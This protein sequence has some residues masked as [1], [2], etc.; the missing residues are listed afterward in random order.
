MNPSNTDWSTERILRTLFRNPPPF[1]VINITL[2]WILYPPLS[3][4]P[5]TKSFEMVTYSIDGA[6]A[7]A[8]GHLNRIACHVSKLARD[9]GA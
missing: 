8:L 1:L 4:L 6:M 9:Y 5:Y 2:F 7:E 3:D